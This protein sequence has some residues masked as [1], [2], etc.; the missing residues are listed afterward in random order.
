[1]KLDIISRERPVKIRDLHCFSHASDTLAGTA[2]PGEAF[3]F[4]ICVLAEGESGE[5]RPLT[6][7]Y[8]GME[9]DFRVC[10]EEI[11]CINFGGRD[12][13]GN[14][15]RKELALADSQQQ[16]LW[17]TIPVPRDA[18][19]RAEGS[20]T[21]HLGEEAESVK[22][23]ISVQGERVL[24][25][26]AD[27][28]QLMTRLGWLN[29]ALAL[30]GG[31]TGSYPSLKREGNDLLTL[32]KRLSVGEDGLP[33]A[34]FSLFDR[35]LHVGQEER[36]VF[37]KMRF[38]LTYADGRQ[39]DF[40]PGGVRFAPEDGEGVSYEAVSR[41]GSMTLTVRGRSEFDG[42]N[43]FRVRLMSEEE[44]EIRDI[45]M[46][47]PFE[48]GFETYM[49]GL[50]RKGGYRP[51]RHDFK[52]D[53]T[54]HQSPVFLGG[55][56]GGA[57]VEFMGE[58]FVEPF[59]NIYYRHRPYHMSRA[60][61]NQ[62]KGGI[63]VESGENGALL[64]A[65]TGSRRMNPGECLQFDFSI[66]LTPLKEFDAKKR[67]GVRYDH[68]WFAEDCVE[69]ARESGAN[70]IIIHHASIANPY[71]NYPFIENERLHN[72][73]EEIHRAGLR[74]KIYYTIREFSD[75]AYE[76]QPFLSLGDEIYPRPRQGM[77][78]I[79]WQP[80]TL[81][82]F[83]QAYGENVI[84]AWKSDVDS[85]LLTDGGSRLCNYYIEGLDYLV[86]THD[87]DGIYIDDTACDR[88]T[89]RRAR[90]ILDQKEGC[91]IDL[92]TW[93]H[94]CDMAGWG[95]SLNIYMP[96]LPYIDSL[97][98]GEEFDHQNEGEDFWIVEIMGLP[99]GMNGELLS[100][101]QDS[102]YRG[103]LFGATH[104][105]MHLE[106]E[107]KYLWRALDEYHIADMELIG[108]WNEECPVKA[109]DS[110]VKVTLYMDR[111]EGRGALAYASF[112]SEEV[113][114]VLED[115]IGM[116]HTR[117]PA[118]KLFQESRSLSPEDEIRVEPGRG[119]FIVFD[120]RGGK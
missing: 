112:A 71:I 114:F 1:M 53:E 76:M 78:S 94:Y 85:A 111:A 108:F 21:V 48:K 45:S 9:G 11:F 33:E 17:V 57:R 79:L 36:Q 98:I 16:V 46:V 29:S 39:A 20:F 60:F 77:E 3:A 107:P 54:K 28:P 61:Y 89:M 22:V 80:E 10:A 88:V 8:G 100:K 106:T 120:I 4:Q 102:Q 50:G 5:S 31:P 64:T 58:D 32:G 86:K 15:F 92:H 35:N 110:R 38:V 72:L 18:A 116:E 51:Q 13:R 91:L 119:G 27:K 68:S 23:S 7:E 37:G 47:L 40:V 43:L 115:G 63:R 109:S 84:P 52:W 14:A 103:L 90:R 81:E 118:I 25:Q 67:F 96:L 117:M 59:V 49:M 82:E 87:I 99:F 83:R 62:G 66:L 70:Y 73:G 42:W 104:R 26:G 2:A 6:L 12:S 34:G 19:G 95:N 69:Q 56:N 74:M 113:S 44:A 93:N 65:Y 75:Y 105:A 97:W 55:L 41:S 30:Q 24:N 101:V